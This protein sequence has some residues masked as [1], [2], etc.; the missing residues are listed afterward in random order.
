[1][2]WIWLAILTAVS[3]VSAPINESCQWD[4]YLGNPGRTAYTDCKGPDSPEV[5]WEIYL[6][7]ESDT[8]FIV[9]DKVIVFSRFYSFFP[10]PLESPPPSNVTVI[11]LLT[12][13]LLQKVIPDTGLTGVH[14]VGDTILIRS[15]GNL[16]KI[17]LSSGKTSFVSEIPG[18]HFCYPGCYALILPDK[19]VLPTTPLVCLSRDDYSI[20]W[21]LETSLGSL[22]SEKAEIWEIAAS[23]NQVYVILEGENGRK[24]L[25]VNLE[26]GN[27]IWMSELMVWRIATDDSYVFV[28]GDNLYALSAETG[29]PL[30]M[31]ELDYTSSNIAI[32]P[33][34]VYLT[35]IKNYVYAV[36]RKTGELM[37]KSPW[38]ETRFGITYIVG[39]GDTIICS[40]LLNLTAF[41]AED[42][43]ELW[44]VHFRDYADFDSERPCPAVAEDIL[45]F[46]K[47]EL[48]Q[49]DSHVKIKPEQLIALASDPDLF[50]KQ[51]D[52]FLSENQKD[53]AINSYKKAAELYEWK[54][55][56]TTSQEIHN[57]IHELENLS[58]SAPPPIPAETTPAA[59]PPATSSPAPESPDFLIP[60]VLVGVLIGVLVAYHFVTY[61]KSK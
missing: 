56:L 4:Q 28:A 22:Y 21:N 9:G 7:G 37:W 46:V 19:I 48:Q 1:M 43:T 29:E 26:T 24:V 12:G 61:K 11:D 51:G 13:T 15:K 52:A 33:T 41:S 39:V 54:E 30:W 35:D 6:D 20:L 31:L 45:V 34:A 36:D 50:V 8:P 53:R 25:A 10:P 18:K 14:P 38:E 40:N 58:E 17:D 47:K 23:K 60:L 49:G 44:N 2:K 55:D 5:L 32:G 27:L 59:T 3:L 16:H 57:R 42:G